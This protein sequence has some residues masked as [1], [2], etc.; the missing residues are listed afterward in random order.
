MPNVGKCCFKG[1]EQLLENPVNFHKK[2]KRGID[3]RYQISMQNKSIEFFHKKESKLNQCLIKE[4]L[5]VPQSIVS[6][7]IISNSALIFLTFTTVLHYTLINMIHQ[8]SSLPAGIDGKVQEMSSSQQD[9]QK[10]QAQQ[11]RV[12]QFQAHFLPLLLRGIQCRSQIFA[13]YAIHQ[14][15]SS[16]STGLLEPLCNILLIGMIYILSSIKL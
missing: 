12:T 9:P 10:R 11:Q 3:I 16:S 7:M 6:C 14:F 1:N 13:R 15:P 4:K 5:W 8:D 2:Q